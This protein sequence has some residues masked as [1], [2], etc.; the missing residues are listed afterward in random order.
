[1]WNLTQ[2]LELHD[3]LIGCEEPKGKLSALN[4]CFLLMDMEQ[5]LR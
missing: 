3:D 1:M 4:D 5:T 2:I